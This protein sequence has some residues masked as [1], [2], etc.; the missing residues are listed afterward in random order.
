MGLKRFETIHRLFTVSPLSVN[1]PCVTFSIN[2]P[3]KNAPIPKR[4]L[5]ARGARFTGN[6]PP[7]HWE[8]VKP[9]ASHIRETCQRVYTPGTHVTIDEVMLTYRG[10]S[11]NTT[12]LKNKPIREGFKNWV[13]INHGYIWRW[14][15]HSI[16]NGSE[17][18]REP[19]NPR[20]LNAL[21]ETQRIIMRLALALPA[22]SLDYILYLDNL[23]SSL[24][25][26]K[27]LKKV[28]ISITGTIRKNIK[29]IPKWLLALKEKNKELIWNS[30]LS[31]IIKG[32]F[33]FL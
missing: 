13:L 17:G 7:G 18:A 30:A 28:F 14:E 22:N 25:L 1:E 21:P 16:K 2:D 12:K 27:A 10:R 29:S 5:I 19:L 23:F 31:E 33:I 9:L 20:I 32:V 26:A 6:L 24:L 8:K 4:K 11:G 3:P 15:W